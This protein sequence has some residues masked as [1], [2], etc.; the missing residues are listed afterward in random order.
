M[1]CAIPVFN[2][3]G[4]RNEAG[5]IT[6]IID[7]ILQYNGHTERMSFAVTNLGKQDIILGFTWL[8][9]HNL[10]IDWQTWKVVMSQCPDKCHTCRMD[11]QKQQQE[12]RKVDR[13]VQVCCSGP[14]PLLLEEELEE[15]DSDDLDS[16]VVSLGPEDTLE[17]GEHLVLEP[18]KTLVLRYNTSVV[19]CVVKLRLVSVSNFYCNAGPNSCNNYSS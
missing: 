12:Q 6:E 1:Q 3:D 19:N 7:T 13:L 18:V 17:G 10:E 2:V 15:L 5:S 16:E 14:H 4:T 8:Q 9:E 11:I